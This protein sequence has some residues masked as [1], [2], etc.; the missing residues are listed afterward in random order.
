[1]N[2][3]TIGASLIVAWF[4]FSIS[5]YLV[6]VIILQAPTEKRKRL[7]VKMMKG[8]LIW[9]VASMLIMPYL[10]GEDASMLL[11]ISPQFWGYFVGAII[12]WYLGVWF[13]PK[14]V[15]L[16]SNPPS[17][18]RGCFVKTHLENFSSSYFFPQ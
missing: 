1:M 18:K 3:I 9:F 10:I 4:S 2:A 14:R 12:G 5:S 7:G 17:R 13:G 11:T 6:K 8:M 15:S 16:T